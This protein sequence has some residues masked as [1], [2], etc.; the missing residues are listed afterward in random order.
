MINRQFATLRGLAII[1]MVFDHVVQLSLVEFGRQGLLPPTGF[2]HWLLIALRQPDT[3]TVPIFLFLSG[4]FIVYAV[5]GRDILS[6]Y[7]IVV[8]SLRYIM[9]PYIV[10]SLIFYVVAY[11]LKYAPPEPLL[12]YVK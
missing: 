3:I 10:W 4:G 7:K 5:S 9:V 6:A 11:R 12:G 2:G 1:L 8:S